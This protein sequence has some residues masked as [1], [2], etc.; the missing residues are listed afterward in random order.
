MERDGVDSVDIKDVLIEIR[1]QRMGLIQTPD[2]LRFSYQAIIEG[3]KRFD[4]D[5]VSLDFIL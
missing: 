3:I 1:S 4:P 5:Y 2:Q